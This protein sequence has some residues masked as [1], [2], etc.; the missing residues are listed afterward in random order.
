EALTF[1]SHYFRDVTTKFNRPN[2]NMDCPPPTC[3]FQVFKSLCKS[4]GLWSV[5]RIDHQELKKVIWYVLY[6]SP[7]IDT[8]R[9]K[10]K[11]R[12]ERR[13]TQNSGIFSPG[14][15]DGEMYYGQLEEILEF[16]YMSFKVVLF[17]V[18]WFDT[19]NEGRKVKRFVIRNNMTQIWANDELFKDDQYILATQVKQVFYLEDMARLPPNWKVVEDVN[20]KKFSNG[21]V[22]VVEDDYDVIHFDNSSDLTLCTSLNDLDFATLH[23]DGQSMDVDAPPDIIDVDEDNDIIDD[24]DVLPYDLADSDDEDLINVDD[25]DVAISAD[26]ARGHDGNGGGDDR[27]PPHHTGGGCRGKGTRKPNLGGRKAGRLNTCKETR[28]LGL[29]KITNQFG[30]QAIRFEWSDRDTLMPFGDHAAHGANLLGE[31]VREFL[32]HFRSWHNI[33]EERKAGVMG[34]IRT[35]FDLTPHVQSDLSSKI[36]KGIEQ[37]L[38]K[39]YTKNKSSLKA[40]HW[41][42]NPDD[43][44]YDMEGIR[45]RRPVNI[46]VAYWD[47]QIAFWS[48]P[49][50]TARCA[51][52]SRNRAK[53][54]VICRHGSQSLAVLRDRQHTSVTRFLGAPN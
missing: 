20:N 31:I 33:L 16:S 42:A 46:S 1:S 17:R 30:P 35:Q 15:K 6:N 49:K 12:D 37:H 32:M 24:E 47:V 39:I 13:T 28:N 53:S 50:N 4:I 25:D 29:R 54:T 19:S 8:Y 51:Q 10:F 40:E 5:I 18:K 36:K 14:D 34:K 3:Q 11:S 23:I 27:P 45:S 9:A 26:V 52:N 22:I 43:G 44:T 2:R 7:E 48:D 21:G 38:A 41:V